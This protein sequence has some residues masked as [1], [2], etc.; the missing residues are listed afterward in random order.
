LASTG[1]SRYRGR[2]LNTSFLQEKLDDC[3]L[4]LLEAALMTIIASGTCTTLHKIDASIR[5]AMTS[6][7]LHWLTSLQGSATLRFD[8]L[9]W[10]ANIEQG[11]GTPWS[12][13]HAHLPRMAAALLLILATHLG[14]PL[15]PTSMKRGNL[16]FSGNGEALGSGCD[17]VDGGPLTIWDRPDQWDVDALILSGSAEVD[18]YSPDDTVLNAGSIGLGMRSARRVRPAIIRNDRAWRQK[19]NGPL[20]SWKQAVQQEFEGWRQRVKDLEDEVSK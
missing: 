11:A 7:W 5:G 15:T 6:T 14:E 12:G 1:D 4:R 9:R 8:F 13:N 20:A 2:S 17:T 16:S 3:F 19:L 18:V 10:L